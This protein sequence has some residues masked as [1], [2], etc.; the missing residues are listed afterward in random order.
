[1][2][3]YCPRFQEFSAITPLNKPLLLSPA[4]LLLGLQQRTPCFFERDLVT[5]MG[6]LHFFLFSLL[7]LTGRPQIALCSP[8]L[9]SAWPGLLPELPREFFGS[10]NISFNHRIYG[11][12]SSVLCFFVEL[13][14]CSCIFFSISLRCLAVFSRSSRNLFTTAIVLS[15]LSDNSQTSTSSG[16]VTGVVFVSFGGIM[17][18]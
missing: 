1:M 6:C 8:V 5:H 2:S 11:W 10:V 17:F 3:K 16:S 4:P 7:L 18:P 15:S 13:L 14:I 9:S 12:F